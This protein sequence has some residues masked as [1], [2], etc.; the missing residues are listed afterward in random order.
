MYAILPFLETDPY[1]LEIYPKIVDNKVD[2]PEPTLP[3]T[4][5]SSPGAIFNYFISK[6]YFLSLY[7][8]NFSYFYYIF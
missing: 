4:E 6:S 2:L 3:T 8:N 5:T 1:S 7:F